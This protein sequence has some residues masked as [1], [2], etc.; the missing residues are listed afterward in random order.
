MRSE[1]KKARGAELAP[2]IGRPTEE[3]A[4][5]K[6]NQFLAVAQELFVELGYRAV[7]MRLVAERAQVSTRTL[8]NHYKD[9]A[10][11]FAACL[12]FGAA[13]FPRLQL[14][15]DRDL[16]GALQRYAAEL[17]R[18]LSRDAS[19]QLG[20]LVYREGGDFPELLRASEANYEHYLVQPLAASLSEGG[21]PPNRVEKYARL[22]II[23]ALSEWQRTVVYQRPPLKGAE[24]DRHAGLVAGVF[25]DGVL[26]G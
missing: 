12:D 2:R 6:K 25:L 15:V 22:F 8:Y 3:E 16:R 9:K 11:L 10:T 23:M 26:A 4:R 5:I 13:D 7:S 19:F 21:L 18:I 24:I 14:Q 17:V 20:M 1:P